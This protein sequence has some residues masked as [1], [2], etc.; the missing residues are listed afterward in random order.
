MVYVKNKGRI[1]VV[2]GCSMPAVYK[3]MCSRHRQQILLFGK[4]RK[5]T[6]DKNSISIRGRTAIVHLRDRAAK[7]VSTSLIDVEDIDKIKDGKWCRDTR[8]YTTGSIHGQNKKMHQIIY[9]LPIEKGYEIDHINRD[10]S[11]NRKR[12]LRL[13]SHAANCRNQKIFSTNKSGVRGVYYHKTRKYW[14][15]SIRVNHKHITV[16][17]LKSLE[18]AKRERHMLEQKHWQIM[19]EM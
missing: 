10:K 5:T 18:D 1:C 4:I 3:R 14:V 13:V 9:G 19:E 16:E 2:D 7:T 12:N 11:D 15:A 17:S 6:R 8:G